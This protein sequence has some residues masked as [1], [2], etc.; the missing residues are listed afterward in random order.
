MNTTRRKFLKAT[1]AGAV[2]SAITPSVFGSE[3]KVP[4]SRPT[5]IPKEAFGANDRIRVA[6]LGVNGRGQNHIE[7]VMKQQN[8]E[9]AVLCD[10]DLAVLNQQAKKFEEKYKKKIAVEQDFRKVYENKNID[11]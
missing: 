10:P 2:V 11:A 7:E 3:A 1:A 4:V 9:V 5:V 8:A 6:V